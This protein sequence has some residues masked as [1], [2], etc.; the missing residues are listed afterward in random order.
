MS[1]H[2][3]ML[4]LYITPLV[5][6]ATALVS[7]AEDAPYRAQLTESAAKLASFAETDLGRTFVAVADDLPAMGEPRTIYFRRAD[8]STLTPE[9]H[10]ALP[11]EERSTYAERAVGESMYYGLFSTPLA[12]L[13]A[14]DLASQAGLTSVDGARVADFGFGNLG[15]LRMLA[16]MGADATGIEI[17]GMHDCVFRMPGDQ[18][19]VDRAPEAGAGE[20]GRVS[21]VFGQYP[22]TDA[23]RSAVGTGYALFMSK[24]TLK[25]G[26]I[27]P[28]RPADPKQLVHLGVDDE[29]FA[30]AVYDAL[31]PGGLF[32]IY[33]L[34]PKPAAPDEPYV[35]WASGECPFERT[36][37]ETV[38]FTVV[39]WNTDD[40]DKARAMGRVLGWNEGQTDADYADGMNAMFTILR[41]TDENTTQPASR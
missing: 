33:N 28:E 11:E 26:Y 21:L 10:A 25:K 41:R 9:E 24:N 39:A 16:S 31:A 5:I 36:L 34:Y 17:D 2:A 38:G 1:Y 4:T 23:I 32:I 3:A 15:Q 6:A 7:A 8:R 14:L 18:G 19:A 13:R 35:P 29:T 20:P 27:H 30:R 37:L 40:T 22:A 12:Y